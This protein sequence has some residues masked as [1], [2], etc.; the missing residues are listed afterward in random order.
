M[1]KTSVKKNLYWE[2]KDKVIEETFDGIHRE[3]TNRKVKVYGLDSTKS[4]RAR[5]IEILM[6][7]S[8][9][10]KDKFIAPVLW[11]EM[12]SMEVKKSGKVE[13]SDK[14]HDDNVFSYL[15]ALYVWYEGKNLV[16]NFGIRKTTI[17]TDED[18]EIENSE[19]EDEL[20]TRERIDFRG[21]EFEMDPDIAET[22][23]ELE[24]QRYITTEHVREQ[25]YLRNVE[26]RNLIIGRMDTSSTDDYDV[27]VTIHTVHNP[28]Y[29]NFARMPDSL[30]DMEDTTFE[31]DLSNNM[32]RELEEPV[33]GNLADIFKRL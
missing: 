11:E 10:H 33:A 31:L 17:R 3:K 6:E 27:G 5:L 16:E 21:S 8:K 22:L 25:E 13:H 1:V 9:Y 18:I 2:I 32:Q 24:S 15:M 7:R 29:S 19:F 30:Y 12:R 4:V 23:E 14:T 26:Q 28:Q 20:E